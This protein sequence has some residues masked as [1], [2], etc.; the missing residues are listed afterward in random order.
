MPVDFLIIT[1]FFVLFQPVY[2]YLTVYVCMHLIIYAHMH[3]SVYIVVEGKQKYWGTDC[4]F[5]YSHYFLLPPLYWD[6]IDITHMFKVYHVMIRYM[7][8]EL[9]FEQLGGS[10]YPPSVQLKIWV[11]IYI[12]IY[13]H[14]SLSECVYIC[15]YLYMLSMCVC[16][17]ILIC[18]YV[19]G[20]PRWH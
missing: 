1:L 2:V 13:T 17:Y 16:V 20:F 7:Y 15:I 10:W 6:S 5:K 3:V 11:Y 19:H 14:I 12:Y 4:W 8:T 18:I 9:P